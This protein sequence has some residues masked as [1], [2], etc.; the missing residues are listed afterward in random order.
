[1]YVCEVR[2]NQL[3]VREI[4]ECKKAYASIYMPFNV[5]VCELWVFATL[6]SILIGS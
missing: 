3:C 1:M 5:S 4:G 2:H 6:I